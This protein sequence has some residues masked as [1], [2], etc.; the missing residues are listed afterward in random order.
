MLTRSEVAQAVGAPV[1]GLRRTTAIG[2]PKFPFCGF[3]TTS[4]FGEVSVG[5][6]F[7]RDAYAQGHQRAA[8]N[9]AIRPALVPVRGL[10]NA[11]FTVGGGVQVLK[12]DYFLIVEP[13]Y[14]QRSDSDDFTSKAIQLASKAVRRLP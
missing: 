14:G 3:V 9:T 1:T 4:G 2:D 12:G 7:G 10:G 6:R 11:A 13:Q 5:V 8:A